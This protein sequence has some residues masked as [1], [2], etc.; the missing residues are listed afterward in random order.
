[1][2][3]D[4]LAG[5]TVHALVVGCDGVVT[6][7]YGGAG[8][9]AGWPYGEL[10]G[11]SVLDVL[12]HATRA[13]LSGLFAP[14]AAT[15]I[16]ARALSF[17]AVV[18]GPDGQEEEFDVSPAGFDRDGCRGWVVTISSRSDL[19]PVGD[20]LRRMIRGDAL[21]D[22]GAAVARRL[23]YDTADSTHLS[24]V[25]T[26]PGTVRM[27]LAAGRP[28]SALEPAVRATVES[29]EA[30]LW[31]APDS[32]EIVD[33]PLDTLPAEV[34]T[35][36]EADGF[37]QLLA[38]RIE[39]G[40]R[41]ALVLLHF[42]RDLNVGGLLGNTR[43]AYRELGMA[44]TRAVEREEGERLLREAAMRDPLTGLYNRAG[45][46]EL[47]G[48]ADLGS[49]VVFVDLDHFKEVNDRYGHAVGDAVLVEIAARMRA[50]LRPNDHVAR[51][52]GDEFAA[53]VDGVTD[54]AAADIAERLL[55]AVTDPLPQHLGPARVGASIGVAHVGDGVTITDAL[56]SADLAMLDAKRAGRCR[57]VVSR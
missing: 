57:F 13:E 34:V 8:H 51:L 53:I 19:S 56:K 27:T 55:M 31:P 20:V 5:M 2:P 48:N 30:C 24:L 4:V 39:I 18:V 44:L 28:G 52:G 9:L 6:G 35:A 37:A 47:T 7:A 40:Q 33:V 26:W 22:V 25:I 54:A 11:R 41:N 15:P 43:L 10:V 42:A 38:M 1:M 36:M 3:E 21:A 23:T 17:P 45:F 32:G 16:A 50:V 46:G 29:G 49:A 12:G 14:G